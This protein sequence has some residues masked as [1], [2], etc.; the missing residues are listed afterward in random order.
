MSD[1]REGEERTVFETERPDQILEL[2]DDDD[3]DGGVE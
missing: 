2:D 3:N 1:S